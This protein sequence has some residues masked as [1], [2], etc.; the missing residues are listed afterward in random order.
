MFHAPE[1][2]IGKAFKGEAVVSLPQSLDNTANG[3]LRERPKGEIFYTFHQ[4]A[5]VANRTL[6]VTMIYLH[7]ALRFKHILHVAEKIS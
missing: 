4:K 2:F 3:C 7:N 6:L 1:A 5:K